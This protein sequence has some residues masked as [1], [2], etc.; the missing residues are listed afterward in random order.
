[1]QEVTRFSE[2]VVWHF[3]NACYKPYF[4]CARTW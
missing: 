3:E 2:A 4:F 1:M